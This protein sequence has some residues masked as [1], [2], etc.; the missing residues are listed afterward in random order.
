MY[1]RSSWS[2][3]MAT[4]PAMSR[5]RRSDPLDCFDHSS[6]A[7]T[8]S[9]GEVTNTE[10]PSRDTAIRRANSSRLNGRSFRTMKSIFQPDARSMTLN[11]DRRRRVSRAASASTSYSSGGI[12]R[13]KASRASGVAGSIT[14]STS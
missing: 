13:I 8:V 5:R 11:I 1:A 10:T 4:I 7:R 14:M 2:P 3:D 9:S 12:A 6:L